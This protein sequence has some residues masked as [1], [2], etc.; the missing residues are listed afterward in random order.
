MGRSSQNKFDIRR[1]L[2]APIF[3]EDEDKTRDAARLNLVALLCT[4]LT[5][6]YS[7]LWVFVQ[8]DFLDRL[9]YAVILVIM[10]AVVL[11]LIHAGRVNFA[12]YVFLCG[13]WVIV[14]VVS[15][16]AGGTRAP[17]FALYIVIIMTSVLFTGW[18]SALFYGGITLIAGM[19]MVYGATQGW[20]D[21]PFATPMSAWLTQASVMIFVTLNAYIILR[22]IR[23]ALDKA[24]VALAERDEK[25]AGLRESE[26]RFRLIS[27]LTTDYTYASQ[28]GEDGQIEHMLLEGAFERITGYK[29]ENYAKIGGWHRLLHPDDREKD[30]QD[31]KMLQQNHPII[32]ELRIIKKGGDVC[33]VRI[34]A[35]PVWDEKENRL[36]GINGAVKD[37]S[38]EKSLE[39]ELK[40]SNVRLE[41]LVKERTTELQETKDRLELVLNNTT[42]ALAFA[43]TGG[44]ILIANPA[45]H[46]TFTPEDSN[47]IEFILWSIADEQQ[48]AVVSEAL[49]KAIYDKEFN[50]IETQ[51]QSIEGEAKDIDLILIPVTVNDEVQDKRAG[52]LLSGHDITKMK[53]IE[54]FK[55]RFVADAVHDLATPISGI[56]TRLYMLKRNPERIND[57][58]RA[59]ENQVHHLRSLLDNLRTLSRLDR[60]Q[61]ELELSDC[62]L[63]DLVQRVFDTYEPVAIEKQQA[64][65]LHLDSNLPELQV[66]EGQINRVVVNLVSNAINYTEKG[67]SIRVETDREDGFAIVRVIDDGM[68][69]AEDALPRVFDRFY[70]S[71]NAR[72]QVSDG[73][74]LGLAISKEIVELHGGRVTVSSTTGK[75]S[76]FSMYLLL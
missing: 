4:T 24:G 50:R 59:L 11:V 5:I 7:I 71:D 56:S 21:D 33:P 61:L 70:R 32:T 35:Q 58:V 29:P 40:A 45:F 64:L 2:S 72:S 3:M 47:S 1:V 8:P 53:E 14:T 39:N 31:M 76:T 57:H 30:Q 16:T 48:V 60:N 69:I 12:R 37:I 74:G 41:K 22:D 9:I 18:R 68:G 20:I 65:S 10:C 46:E 23:K 43:D 73:T 67:K 15:A 13:F 27:S 66:D 17:F 38:E 54:R 34:Y 25:E 36:A 49:V 26:E 44:N 51:I 19:G 28:I 52:V 6:L 62:N 75:G 55:A 42:N 63:N